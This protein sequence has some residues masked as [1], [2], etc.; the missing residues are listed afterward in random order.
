[1]EQPADATC[2]GYY[3]RTRDHLVADEEIR[4]RVSVVVA[5][6]SWSECHHDGQARQAGWG[7]NDPG[8]TAA[9]FAGPSDR[10]SLTTNDETERRFLL[11]VIKDLLGLTEM[12]RG[13]DNKAVD[14]SNIVYIVSQYH[15][16]QKAVSVR[17]R[18]QPIKGQGS[19]L[20]R[21]GELRLGCCRLQVSGGSI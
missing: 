8:I 16:R 21:W 13:E 10:F 9:S 15:G 20:H 1:M 18:V 4:E 11:T 2:H 19:I 17:P 14:A 7:Q 6:L 12:N 3:L 5:M